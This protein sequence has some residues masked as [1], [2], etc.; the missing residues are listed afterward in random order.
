MGVL[1]LCMPDII[2]FLGPQYSPMA[3]VVLILGFSKLIDLG[4][5]LNSHLLLTSK[6]WKIEFFTNIFLVLMAGVFNYILV[7]KYGILGSAIATLIAFSVYNLVRFVLIWYL[8]KMQP[9]DLKN[10]KLIVIAFICFIIVRIIPSFQNV[11]LDIF[12]RSGLFLLLY[13]FIIV[14]ARIS[15]DIND[16]LKKT[17]ARF[18]PGS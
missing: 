10:L 9:F 12:M 8:F 18:F 3:D 5:G 17:I 13:G 15:E 6:H 1:I 2:I 14:R 7:R 4:T 16:V 11:Y